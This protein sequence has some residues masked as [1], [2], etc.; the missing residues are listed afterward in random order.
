MEAREDKMPGLFKDTVNRAGNTVF[1]KPEEVRGT[2]IK[3]CEFYKQ[4]SLGIPGQSL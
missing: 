3:G 2:L 4:L 1:V